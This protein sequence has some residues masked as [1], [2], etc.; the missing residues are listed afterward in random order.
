VAG[1]AGKSLRVRHCTVRAPG[2]AAV[3]VVGALAGATLTLEDAI[4]GPLVLSTPTATGSLQLHNCIVS[5]DGMAG[6]AVS[7]GQLDATLTNV[8]ILGPSAF[9]SL[10]ATNVLFTEVVNVQRTQAGCVRY[11][12][13]HDCYSKTG[14]HVPRRFRCLPDLARAAA[15]DR[16]GDELSLA[17]AAAADL[18]VRPLFLDTAL[19]EPTCAML[20]PLA[21]DRLRLGGEAEVE[22]GAL[23]LAAEGVRMANIRRL[24]DEALP[25][26]LEAG[27]IDDTRSSATARRRNVP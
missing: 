12:Y 8:T 18:S 23:A 27:L 21:S 5:S 17:E 2:F 26:G 7:A 11:S 15:R 10:E 24:F 1:G 9:K 25:F 6:S 4:L 13:V 14:S 19:D 22:I 20:H 16:K 3:N